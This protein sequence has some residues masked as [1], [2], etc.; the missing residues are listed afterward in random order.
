M[1]AGIHRWWQDGARYT[2]ACEAWR[3]QQQLRLAH[4]IA[5]TRRAEL[6]TMRR[7]VLAFQ[8]LWSR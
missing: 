1:G 3:E 5:K 6:G 2:E 4:A 7:A 8:Q